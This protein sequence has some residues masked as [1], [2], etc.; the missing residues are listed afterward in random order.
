MGAVAS[1][2]RSSEREIPAP[3]PSCDPN[4][5]VQQGFLPA[6]RRSWDELDVD[7]AL[8]KLQAQQDRARDH[9]EGGDAMEDTSTT[10]NSD[11][12]ELAV[13]AVR[14]SKPRGGMGG[15]G[16]G[17][18]KSVAPQS[19]AGRN[20]LASTTTTAQPSQPGAYRAAPRRPLVPATDPEQLDGSSE[21]TFRPP[22]SSSSATA[23]P[24]Q[25][26]I[27]MTMSAL[28]SDPPLDIGGRFPVPQL[29][30]QQTLQ[31][32]IVV[33]ASV[34]DSDRKLPGGSATSVMNSSIRQNHD[35]SSSKLFQQSATTAG[36]IN[37][38][39]LSRS[40]TSATSGKATTLPLVHAELVENRRRRRTLWYLALLL[41]LGAV[42]AAVLALTL[43]RG[44]N[45]NNGASG[46]TDAP[47]VSPTAAPTTALAP[48]F[49]AQLPNY[50]LQA[51]D[52][53]GHD[54]ETPQ[55]Q[56][57]D[58]VIRHPM[59]DG[60]SNETVVLERMDQ[61]LA[62]AALYY[63]TRGGISWKLC[64]GCSAW[65]DASGSECDWKGVKCSNRRVKLL[66]LQGFRLTGTLPPELALL[67]SSLKSFDG[68]ENSL[69]GTM[70]TEL[71]SLTN[72]TLLSLYSNHISGSI[73]SEFGYLTALTDLDLSSNRLSRTLPTELGR[74][75][76][77]QRILAAD[78]QLTGS[79]PSGVYS[80]SRLTRLDLPGNRI[81]STLS[82]ELAK[83]TEL[84]C[85]H[86]SKNRLSGSLPTQLGLLSRLTF[87]S[88]GSNSWNGTV[89]S[90]IGSLTALTS[91]RLFDT[92]D[93][94][95]TIPWDSFQ[96]LTQL[97]DLLLFGNRGLDPAPFSAAPVTSFPR[98]QRLDWSDGTW[99]GSLPTDFAQ[100]TDL[101]NVSL[102]GNDLNGTIP[103]EWG[104]LTELQSLYLN[105]NH[106]TGTIP[107]ELA[108]LTKLS[109]L[110]LFGNSLNGTVPVELCQRLVKNRVNFTV[111]CDTVECDPAKCGC[112]CR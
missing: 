108:S 45:N 32:I 44:N 103:T 67:Q 59:D 58:W 64:D 40:G 11:D 4:I 74:L 93:L 73:P 21:L 104:L 38:S 75:V 81:T 97:T 62:L 41:G 89:P 39:S 109:L 90:E 47:S 50:T 100:L 66:L 1:S 49:R 46:G 6:S 24:P 88:A 18:R 87:L 79:I 25:T 84:K 29:L 15:G 72:L 20:A 61:R 53:E 82:T 95:G 3:A 94:R 55:S 31:E 34:V 16:T 102:S 101:K 68:K 107:T 65:L 71:G 110:W 57:Y 77:L 63:A 23:I 86:L 91:L 13:V 5:P 99:T 35:S 43:A 56:A 112:S 28:T 48:N 69:T 27:A 8:S 98:L 10:Q 2:G 92:D 22:P 52:V 76:R 12:E 7:E 33:D 78:N 36:T 96:N 80:L 14:V 17:L 19:G 51:L 54:S 111:D 42:I 30:P 105:D 9:L 85:L 37:T 83:L 106:L 60:E 70:P 26:T